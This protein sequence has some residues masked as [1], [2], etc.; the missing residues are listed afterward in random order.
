MAV[1]CCATFGRILR[2]VTPP[3]RL[4]LR[5]LGCPIHFLPLVLTLFTVLASFFTLL[6]ASIIAATYLRMSL[7][8]EQPQQGITILKM[9]LILQSIAPAASSMIAVWF[10]LAIQRWTPRE[11]PL[12]TTARLLGNWHTLGWAVIVSAVLLMVRPL[13]DLQHSSIV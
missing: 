6:G 9:G 13:H 5:L 2:W 8:E 3:E 12:P 7:L 4:Q 10:M 1:A 11:K